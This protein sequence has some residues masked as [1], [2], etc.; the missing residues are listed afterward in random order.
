MVLQAEAE[1]TIKRYANQQQFALLKKFKQ[2][3]TL[4]EK[5]LT[6]DLWLTEQQ[7]RELGYDALPGQDFLLSPTEPRT[8]TTKW[9]KTEQNLYGYIPTPQ[10]A[11][12]PTI[13][14][15]SNIPPGE[16]DLLFLT[17]IFPSTSI[18][19]S[20]QH[21]INLI[22]NDPQ[23]LVKEITA[24]GRNADTEQLLKALDLDL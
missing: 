18:E 7:A 15:I 4:G 21:I 24:V 10:S 13:E 19:E 2:R 8:T 6:T 3:G 14:P 11:E 22:E 23:Q 9:G 1:Q 20:S 16:S 17:R 12:Q 5:Q